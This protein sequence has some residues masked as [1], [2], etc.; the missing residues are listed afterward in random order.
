MNL[1]TGDL[2]ASGMKNSHHLAVQLLNQIKRVN[3]SVV[4]N[5]Q[6]YVLLCFVLFY[7]FVIYIKHIILL[8]Y[9]FF[10][11]GYVR[12]VFSLLH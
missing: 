7:C 10:F 4:Q 5:C 8:M 6:W 3:L 12:I 9:F 1:N 2:L 11:F